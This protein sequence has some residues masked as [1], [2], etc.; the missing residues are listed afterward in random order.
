MVL[1]DQGRFSRKG[2]GSPNE[3]PKYHPARLEQIVK[4]TRCDDWLGDR[5]NYD[6]RKC[7]QC[8]KIFNPSTVGVLLPQCDVPPGASSVSH[9]TQIARAT[10][11][12][13][14]AKP[15]TSITSCVIVLSHRPDSDLSVCLSELLCLSNLAFGPSLNEE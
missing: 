10:P 11:M 4:F 1:P 5:T 12:K 14:T 15:A 7:D 13:R 8:E 3:P 9:R 6:K 2:V